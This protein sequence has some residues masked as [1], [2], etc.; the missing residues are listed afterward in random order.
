MIVSN[1]FVK[2]KF[3][4]SQVLDILEINN[5][6]V[7][8]VNAIKKLIVAKRPSTDTVAKINSYENDQPFRNLMFF[9]S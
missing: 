5:F 6:I 9:L 3:L 4:Y 8:L 1:D 7:G 2:L